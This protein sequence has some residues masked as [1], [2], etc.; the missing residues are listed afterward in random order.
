MDTT[1]YSTL[2]QSKGPFATVLTDVGHENEN[3]EHE[4]QL[5][6]RAASEQLREQGADEGV[7]TAVSERLGE[8]VERPSPVARLVVATPDGIAHDEVAQLRVDQPVATWGPLPDLARWIEHRDATVSFVLAV[9]DHEGGDVGLYSSDLPDPEELTSAGGDTENIHQ[10]GADDWAALKF[11]H[12][13]ENVWAQN[14]AA[15]A[16]AIGSHVRAGTRLVLLAGEGRSRSLVHERLNEAVATVVELEHGSRAEDG[17]D[18]AQASAVREAL[19]EHVVRRRLGLVHD[20][21]ERLGRG[22]GAVAGVDE[23]ADAFVRGQVDTLLIDPTAA[24]DAQLDPAKHPGLV[25]GE[26]DPDGPLR[27]DL[28]LVSAA[29]LTAAAVTAVRSPSLGGAPVAALLRWDQDAAGTA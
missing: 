6:V 18:E 26:T 10:K 23:V 2:Y 15:V 16:D 12:R 29:V 19:L 11:Q 13:T 28:G 7:V 21:Q 27:A 22:E 17:G 8:L 1:T 9:V 5:R 14:A 24:A 25:L 20:L 4:H 3:G